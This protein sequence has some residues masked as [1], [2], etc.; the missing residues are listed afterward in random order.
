MAVA[1]SCVPTSPVA[2]KEACRVTVTG[3]TQNDNG[4]YDSTKYPASPEF[5]YYLTF[6]LASAV[7]GKSYAFGVNENGDHTFNNY[8]FPATGS[9]TVRLSNA[10]TD[11]SVATQAVTVQ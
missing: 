6:E 2:V 1:I 7:R 11:A 3:A 5:R 9:W 10:G 8:I 4:T